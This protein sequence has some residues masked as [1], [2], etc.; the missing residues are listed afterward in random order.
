MNRKLFLATLLLVTA[1]SAQAGKTGAGPA[2]SA[3]PGVGSIVTPG[4]HALL[5]T[6]VKDENGDLIL[7][8]NGGV[9]VLTGDQ[10]TQTAAKLRGFEGAIVAGNVI[11][12]PTVLADG[13][14]AV[15]ALNTR[16]GRLT[17]TRKER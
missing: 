1:G 16:N 9:V 12:A 15:I 7:P 3:A 2:G 5:D 11:K 8:G 10:L 4:S 14:P 13:T 17:L 6:T